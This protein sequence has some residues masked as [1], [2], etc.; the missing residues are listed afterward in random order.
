MWFHF[1]TNSGFSPTCRA[2]IPT[3]FRTAAR[4]ATA[5]SWGTSAAASARSSRR[6][7]SQSP[8]LEYALRL[9]GRDDYL[10]SGRPGRTRGG[11]A[12]PPGRI[13]LRG[14]GSTA[15]ARAVEPRAA[16]YDFTIRAGRGWQDGLGRRAGPGVLVILELILGGL[17]LA[18]WPWLRRRNPRDGKALSFERRTRPARRT[19]R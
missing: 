4:A 12:L 3:A 6:S 9:A 5:W 13:Q 18:G 17:P 7:R 10:A 11:R 2:A 14:A 8:N 15:G 19:G 1:G 16:L